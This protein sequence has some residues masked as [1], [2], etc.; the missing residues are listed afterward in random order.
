MHVAVYAPAIANMTWVS[1]VASPC[2]VCF[3]HHLHLVGG[4]Q[5]R[6]IHVCC[7]VCVLCICC[8]SSIL[9]LSVLGHIDTLHNQHVTQTPQINKQSLYR[10]QVS[11]QES[12]QLS[13]SP[14]HGLNQWPHQLPAFDSVLRQYIDEMMGV[15]AAIMRGTCLVCCC[16]TMPL[17][18]CLQCPFVDI[19]HAHHI[20]VSLQW[21]IHVVP[22][23]IHM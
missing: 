1:F 23:G 19:L 5:G 17:C 4:F 11:A 10:H 22:A 16:F 6:P 9:S 15:G 13:P 3:L 20:L 18:C 2:D 7:I 14:V 21:S 12:S 8:A